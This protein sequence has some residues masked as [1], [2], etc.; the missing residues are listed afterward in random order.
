M[1]SR[2]NLH[3]R[4]LIRRL[5]AVIALSAPLFAAAAFA[6]DQTLSDGDWDTATL[7]R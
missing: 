6:A 4:A 3:N 2:R 7:A 1:Q 5:A